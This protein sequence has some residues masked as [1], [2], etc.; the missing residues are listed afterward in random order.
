[1]AAALAFQAFIALGQAEDQLQHQKDDEAKRFILEARWAAGACMRDL[2]MRPYKDN[3]TFA[4]AHLLLGQAE[5]FR[6][7]S[8]I[9]SSEMHKVTVIMCLF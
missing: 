1:V 4:I 2:Q 8:D 6:G 5:I 7:K 3:R 9:A